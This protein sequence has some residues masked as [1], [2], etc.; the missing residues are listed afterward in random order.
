MQSVVGV[1]KSRPQALEGSRELQP[2]G[3]PKDRVNILT[4][5]AADDDLAKV[6][7]VEAEQPGMGKALG[8]TVGGAIGLATGMGAAGAASSI[9][10]PGIGPVIAI[11]LAG[12]AILGTLGAAA[13]GALEKG[14]SDG[15]PAD[16]LFVYEDALRKGRTVVI[17][18]AENGTQAKAARG[19]LEHAGA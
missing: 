12:A 17:T 14:L 19:A 13:G 4:P 16:E 5:Q 6:P 1:F 3:I 15:L 8:A 9:L 18:M 7:T 2:L 11:G 10:V